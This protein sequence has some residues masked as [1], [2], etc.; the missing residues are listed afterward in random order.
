M[1]LIVRTPPPYR[2]RVGILYSWVSIELRKAIYVKLLRCTPVQSIPCSTFAVI[3]RVHMVQTAWFDYSRTIAIKL[4][5]FMSQKT[6]KLLQ[7]W[8]NLKRMRKVKP[9]RRLLLW[10]SKTTLI[11]NWIAPTVQH[12]RVQHRRCWWSLVVVDHVSCHAVSVGSK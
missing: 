12:R 4:D 8:F 11:S 9:M 2:T 10:V 7:R 5:L 3:G 1:P 6:R